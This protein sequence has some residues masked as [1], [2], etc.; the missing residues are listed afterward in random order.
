MGAL[1]L[2]PPR[3]WTVNTVLRREA[4]PP[5]TL[6]GVDGSATCLT[7]LMSGTVP[8]KRRNSLY[9]RWKNSF[10]LGW[11]MFCRRVEGRYKI[12]GTEEDLVLIVLSHETK[13]V[14]IPDTGPN[15]K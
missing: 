7:T 15:T 9:A 5:R 13:F 3:P 12:K 11:S 14:I 2:R 6:K 4:V 10:K 8:E 1:F